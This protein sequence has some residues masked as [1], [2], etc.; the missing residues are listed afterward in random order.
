MTRPADEALIGRTL[1]GKFVVESFI[2]GGAMGAVYRAKQLSLDKWVAIKVLHGDLVGD[3]TFIAR[4]QREAQAASR[5]DH[6]NSMRVLDYGRDDA[7][8]VCYIAMELL[9]GQSLFAL[10]REARGPLPDKRTVDLLRQVLAGLAVAHEMGVVHRDLKPENIIV[11]QSKSD[12]GNVTETVK[13]CDFG[14]AKIMSD[15]GASDKSLE[16]LTSHGVIV[17]TPEYMSPEQGKGEELDVRSDLYSVG[18]ILY[19]MLTGKLPFQADTPI[20]TVLKHL[21]EEPRPPS[22]LIAGVN[23]ALEAICLRALKKEREER[24]ASAREMRA[25]LRD[26]ATDGA[27]VAG[28][29]SQPRGLLDS[30]GEKPTATYDRAMVPTPVRRHLA[31]ETLAAGAEPR[32]TAPIL[33][34]S[35]LALLGAAIGGFVVLRPRHAPVVQVDS[36]PVPPGPAAEPSLEPVV[37]TA[38]S[39]ASSTQP[40]PFVP[41]PVVN[42]K[43]LAAPPAPKPV[44]KST[45]AVQ[46]PSLR[47]VPTNTALTVQMAPLPPLAS[48][49]LPL[50]TATPP[51]PLPDPFD[52]ASVSFVTVKTSHAQP[53]DVLVALPAG[54]F[55]QCYRDGLRAHGSSLRGSGT[56]HVGFS[57]SGHVSEATFAGPADLAAVGQCVANSAIGSDVRNVEAGATGADVDLAFKPD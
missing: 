46:A 16:K 24:F 51:P 37:P 22:Q 45:T 33:V 44:I 41:P 20:A 53:A 39:G 47:P 2:G 13:V 25:A 50:T 31:A 52:K 12:D 40:S 42:A 27:Q 32:R 49:P 11:L 36:Q 35:A 15:E 14:M 57:G 6:R 19:Q 43:P 23:P 56:L 29:A 28:P 38:N 17:G 5:L 34:L 30:S 4:F 1:A 9:D 7:D 8:G 55:N 21:V 48:E 3:P 18:V 10:L 54:R 26:A